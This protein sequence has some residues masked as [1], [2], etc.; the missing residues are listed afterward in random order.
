MK[1]TMEDEMEEISG[2]D[3]VRKEEARAKVTWA[4]TSASA[5][6]DDFYAG[7]GIVSKRN[8]TKR[9]VWYGMVWYIQEDLWAQPTAS[10]VHSTWPEYLSYVLLSILFE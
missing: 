10:R 7:Y 9:K 1:P 4:S 3:E 6:L 2:D 8:E 5:D